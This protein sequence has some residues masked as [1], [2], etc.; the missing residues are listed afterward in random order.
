MGSTYQVKYVGALPV[1]QVQAAVAG[2]LEKCEAT[3]SNWRLDSEIAR[4]NAHQSSEPIAV[5]P[6]F[7]QAL[8]LALEVA[9]ATDGAFDPTVKPLSDCYRAAKRSGV[10]D[11]AAMQAAK[12]CVDWRAVQLAGTQLTKQR[13]QLA[14]DLDGLVA[15]LACDRI[16]DQLAALGLSNCFIEVTGE[17]LCRGEKAPGVPWRIGVVD[18]RADAVGGVTTLQALPLRDLALCTSGDYRNALA[19]DGQRWHHIFDPR[20]GANATHSIVSVSI[21][22]PRA[23]VA[24]ALG[25]AALVLGAE[26]TQKCWPNWRRWGIVGALLLEPGEHGEMLSTEIAWPAADSR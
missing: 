16:A 25:T 6:L 2:E 10:L 26:G 17:V 21:L 22:A 8:A 18:P 9:A 4:I 23:A 5:S 15:G 11:A 3:F 24:D 1:A 13:A 14:F 19:V 12:Q 7:A 20:T